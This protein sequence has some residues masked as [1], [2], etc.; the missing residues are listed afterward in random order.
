MSKRTRGRGRGAAS[1]KRG[2]LEGGV[3]I[4][5]DLLDISPKQ[6]SPSSPPPS[7][8]PG[9]SSLSTQT[10]CHG[11]VTRQA[12]ASGFAHCGARRPL[13]STTRR[14]QRIIPGPKQINNDA[15]PHNLPLDFEH[16]IEATDFHATTGL[17]KT[18]ADDATLLVVHNATSST[19]NRQ[20]ENQ[21]TCKSAVDHPMRSDNFN[22]TQI[23][24]LVDS[25]DDEEVSSAA[26]DFLVKV[27][28]G[29]RVR[30]ESAPLIMKI[31]ARYGDIV[32]ESALQSV[33]YRSSFLES[34]CSIYQRLDTMNI[35]D[36]AAGE[37]KSMLNLV[38]DLELAKV[39][40]GWLRCRV[41]QIYEAKKSMM[42][43]RSLKATKT[44]ALQ[45][46]EGKKKAVADT[47]QELEC[48]LEACRVLQRKLTTLEEDVGSAGVEM[49]KITERYSNIKSKVQRF[50]RHPL[51]SDLL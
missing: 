39:E 24:H 13:P 35:L 46:M 31:F 47:K 40:I 27:E 10:V 43:A 15:A 8:P 11:Y 23:L 41:E 3:G 4:M 44:K 2:G 48:C 1:R 33:E 17:C 28:G 19:A 25:D 32:K 38:S 36:I 37:L 6:P 49:D 51:V 9:F 14:A 50:Y 16:Q 5:E 18:A 34:I 20:P 12:K 45:E 42:E 26:N 30:P 7:P 29:Y 21:E 22:L